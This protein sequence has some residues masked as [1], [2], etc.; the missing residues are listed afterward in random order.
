M[1]VVVVVVTIC[2]IYC[3]PTTKASEGKAKKLAKLE[4]MKVKL[5]AEELKVSSIKPVKRAI[6]NAVDIA[7]LKQQSAMLN[8]KIESMAATLPEMTECVTLPL[9]FLFNSKG[10]FMGCSTTTPPVCRDEMYSISVFLS[11]YQLPLSIYADVCCI[12]NGV[13]T[14]LI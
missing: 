9:H 12:L 1:P 4:A 11:Q 6:K 5:A 10:R 2:R 7:R 14:F 8:R 13:I 3:I